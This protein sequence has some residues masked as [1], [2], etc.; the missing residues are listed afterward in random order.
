VYSCNY[1]LFDTHISSIDNGIEIE[2]RAVERD[3]GDSWICKLYS[4]LL[5]NNKTGRK[6]IKMLRKQ[7]RYANED[8]L[9]V[10]NIF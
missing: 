7:G 1:S 2:V 9:Y 4:Y 5:Q 6:E 3:D 8:V 10:S